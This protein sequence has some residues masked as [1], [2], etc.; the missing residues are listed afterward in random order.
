LPLPHSPSLLEGATQTRGNTPTIAVWV[1][2]TTATSSRTARFRG[3][4]EGDRPQD[5]LP[6][7]PTVLPV[8]GE[9]WGSLGIM[10]LPFR[11][12]PGQ[13]GRV[14]SERVRVVDEIA[15]ELNRPGGVVNPCLMSSSHSWR[16]G[17]AVSLSWAD[18]YGW[19]KARG[20]QFLGPGFSSWTL[21]SMSVRIL[22]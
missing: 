6:L 17:W 18:G 13:V 12:H 9:G 1:R 21:L 8:V 10:A 16:D 14:A 7:R 3:R 15:K 19:S 11:L 4:Q 20:D 22:E 5:R 2:T